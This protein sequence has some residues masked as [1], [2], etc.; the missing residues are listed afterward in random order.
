MDLRA[1]AVFVLLAGC[2]A[3]RPGVR[4]DDASERASDA[5]QDPPAPS[6]RL[7]RRRPPAAIYVGRVVGTAR[8]GEIVE[9]ARSAQA[10]LRMKAAALGADVVKIDRVT[11]PPAHARGTHRMVLLAGR[12][13]RTAKD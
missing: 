7:V 4:A 13:Y 3:T 8:T 9:A 5:L 10:E 11:P 12:A 6:V 2:A 1:V